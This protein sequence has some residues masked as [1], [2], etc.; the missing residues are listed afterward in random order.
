MRSKTKQHIERQ[1]KKKYWYHVVAYECVICGG[2]PVYKERRYN[3]KPAEC[4]KRHEV[5]QDLC[6]NHY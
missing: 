2:G 6:G 3:E 1:D 4:W 5:R